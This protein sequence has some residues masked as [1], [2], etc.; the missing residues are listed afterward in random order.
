MRAVLAV[1]VLAACG[2][3]DR[4]I[5]AADGP[6]QPEA[7]APPTVDSSR[8]YAHSGKQLFQMNSLTLAT[9]MMGTFTGLGT[10]SLTDLAIDK[11]DRML[12]ITFNKL[13]EVD[14]ATGETTLVSEL[15]VDNSTSLSFIP[16]DLNDPSSPD[17]LVTANSFG[18]VF[19]IDPASG[20]TTLLGNY[21]TLPGGQVR[22]SGDLFGV[23]GLG[24]FATV[25]VSPAGSP[26][27]N[28][29]L[30]R[31]DPV[32]WVATPIGSGTGFD[33]IFGLG[34]W[35]GKIYG[36]VDLGSGNGGQMIEIDQNTG[37]GTLLSSS[38]INWFGAG[39]ATDAPVLE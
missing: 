35:G 32:T 34:F 7:D 28:D 20:T 36:F 13:Y 18:D 33:K 5:P 16:Q 26:G 24:I 39:V 29:F 6:S 38:T 4:D 25:D 3:T 17:I 19:Q 27:G 23:R 10:Q 37:V 1:A 11:N 15:D 9:T 30:A 21:G 8:V 2:P 31:I 12:G 22:S 14:P